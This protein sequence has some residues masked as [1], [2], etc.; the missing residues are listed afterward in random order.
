MTYIIYDGQG[1]KWYYDNGTG[2]IVLYDKRTNSIGFQLSAQYVII[3][4]AVVVLWKEFKG[5]YG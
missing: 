4:L 3:V 1:S 5:W 2:K